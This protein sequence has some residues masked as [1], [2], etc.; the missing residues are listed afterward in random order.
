MYLKSVPSLF[1]KAIPNLSKSSSTH[2]YPRLSSIL[3]ARR[4]FSSSAII[5]NPSSSSPDANS[6]NQLNV[7]DRK[8]KRAQKNTAARIALNSK[9]VSDY[10]YVKDGKN[11]A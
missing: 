2:L 10:D 11:L 4:C 3:P 5:T 6:S 1:H 7:F 9:N 8:S